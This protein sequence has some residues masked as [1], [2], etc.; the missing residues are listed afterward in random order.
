MASLVLVGLGDDLDEVADRLEEDGRGPR[1]A[2]T[3]HRSKKA[4]DGKKHAFLR[5]D[6]VEAWSVA[7]GE[8]AHICLEYHEEG[9]G[10]HGTAGGETGD[11]DKTSVNYQPL[12]EGVRDFIADTQ[13]RRTAWA[14]ESGPF[15]LGKNSC[16]CVPVAF[17]FFF[18]FFSCWRFLPVLPF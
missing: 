7:V 8:L 17:P 18:S 5:R 2:S 9:G 1:F 12:I 11:V 3:S 4:S 15:F 10:S 6:E 16:F 14:V 13:V